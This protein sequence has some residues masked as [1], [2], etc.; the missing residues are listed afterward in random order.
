VPIPAI[1]AEIQEDMNEAA[2]N[3][4]NT[5]DEEPL[6]EWDRD[7]PDM[8]VGTCY[9][10]MKE[11]RLAGRQHAIVK[12]FELDIEH[13]DKERYMCCCAALGCP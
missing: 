9:P 4:D 6:Y 12:E 3:V 5:V 8:S 1:S 13:S 10:S 7:N 2:I 11:L